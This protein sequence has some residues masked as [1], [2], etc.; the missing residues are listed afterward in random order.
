[1]TDS[2][3]LTK[4]NIM[5]D[6][7]YDT[8]GTQMNEIKRTMV[9]TTPFEQQ[10]KYNM[11]AGNKPFQASKY[12]SAGYEW[13]AKRAVNDVDLQTDM[14]KV[15]PDQ[16]VQNWSRVKTV[17]LQ[18]EDS[19][20]KETSVPSQLNASTSSIEEAKKQYKRIK[21]RQAAKKKEGYITSPFADYEDT[22]SS[23]GRIKDQ[24][25]EK[26]TVAGKEFE[27]I[28]II[29]VILAVI[30]I[31]IAIYMYI[32]KNK[33]YNAKPASMPN[34]DLYNFYRTTKPIDSNTHSKSS[35]TFSDDDYN[36]FNT[37]TEY[38]KK[39]SPTVEDFNKKYGEDKEYMTKLKND[40]DDG[41]RGADIDED[42]DDG[43]RGADIDEDDD[44]GEWM[45]V[46]DNCCSYKYETSTNKVDGGESKVLNC[47]NLCGGAAFDTSV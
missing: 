44:D 8:T 43:Y 2:I 36:H 31:V 45:E 1:M 46:S 12:P 39:D 27:V 24:L 3:D 26:F 47:G 4:F 42:D 35:K 7:M 28:D 10:P 34:N 30:I 11:R 33:N 40:Y 32:N 22:W 41:Y 20:S 23:A 38:V 6:S 25:E 15:L 19:K 14:D 16:Q 18:K 5:T 9:Y 37:Y 29:I 17:I 13:Y 21:E